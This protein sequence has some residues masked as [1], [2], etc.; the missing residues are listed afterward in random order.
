MFQQI[1][2]FYQIPVTRKSLVV[3]DIDDTIMGFSKITKL[4][5]RET[6]DKHFALTNDKNLANDLTICEWREY[7]GV[8]KPY[9]LDE[10]KLKNF[11]GEIRQNSCELILLTARDP[12]MT[13]ITNSHLAQCEIQISSDRVIHNANKGDAL[14][15]IVK[16][17]PGFSNIIFVD[18]FEK[19]LINVKTRF[20]QDD[21]FNYNLALYKITH[22]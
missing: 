9:L 4:W 18:D 3:L 7:V 5:W 13:E 21:M 20:S 10:I 16:S 17:Y 8:N 12:V 1:T 15:D 11:F 22:N 6:F 19:N 14:A 2:S